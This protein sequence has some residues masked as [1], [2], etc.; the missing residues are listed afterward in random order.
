MCDEQFMPKDSRLYGQGREI[1]CYETLLS[2][3]SN[4]FV[5]PLLDE[6]TAS[7]LCYTSG[8]TG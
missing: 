4:Q 7:S 2:K 3:E 1:Y 5:W 6:N 8:T